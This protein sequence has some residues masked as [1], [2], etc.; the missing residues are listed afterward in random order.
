M[1]NTNQIELR[2]E[3]VIKKKDDKLYVKGTDY[4]NLFNGWIGK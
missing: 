1:Q 3:K 2:N 4:H